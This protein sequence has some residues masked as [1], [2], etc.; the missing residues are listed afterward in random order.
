[1]ESDHSYSV[2]A[3]ESAGLV[4]LEIDRDSL[5]AAW[6][7]VHP[8]ANPAF[9]FEPDEATDLARRLSAAANQVRAANGRRS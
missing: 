5:A 6:H 4:Q 8:D 2:C 3:S 9:L 7:R 1:M